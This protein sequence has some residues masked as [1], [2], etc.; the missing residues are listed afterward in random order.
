MESTNT[1]RE[2]LIKLLGWKAAHVNFDDV[3]EG[4]P[5]HMQGVRPEG[6]PYSPWE[7]LEHMRITQRDILDFCRDPSYQAPKWPDD[8]WPRETFPPTEDTWQES[9]AA[10]RSDRKALQDLVAD[11]TLDLYTQ[12][13]HG[14]GQTYLRE[15][16][17]VADHS[18]YHLGEFVAV[19]RLLGVWK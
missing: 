6:L 16:V 14:D 15:V 18:A 5:S 11:P 1:L 8:Y 12:I 17:L 2:Q 10:F 13:P 3:V 7:L 19:R 4:V 9:V